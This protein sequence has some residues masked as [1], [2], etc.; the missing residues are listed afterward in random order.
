M[1]QTYHVRDTILLIVARFVDCGL[2][3]VKEDVYRP[4]DKSSSARQLTYEQTTTFRSRSK[5]DKLLASINININYHKTTPTKLKMIADSKTIVLVTGANQGIGF[6]TAK[7]LTTE[8]KD[9]HVIMAGRRKEAVEQA[10]SKLQAEGLSVEPLVLDVTSDESITQA[11]KTVSDRHGHLDVLINNAA[12]GNAPKSADGKPL[13]IREEF[14]R[15]LDTNVAGVQAV[16]DAFIPLLEKS[17]RTKRIVFLSSSL[18]SVSSKADPALGFPF[19]T[20]EGAWHYTTSKAAFNMLA[21]HYVIRYE[22][23]ADWKLNI[24]CPGYC[25]TNLNSYEGTNPPEHGAIN[26]CRLATLGPDGESGTF[27]DKDGVVPW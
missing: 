15:I 5:G 7:K 16:T 3:T 4:T 23:R 12:I 21:L 8:H 19:R 6:E 27:S 11:V 18:G 24:S 22:G 26:V 20:M 1:A 13:S 9:Y 25:S 2:P 10:A 17:D 14:L